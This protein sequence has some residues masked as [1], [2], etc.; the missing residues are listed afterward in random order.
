MSRHILD[1]AKGASESQN[2]QFLTRDRLASPHPA[3]RMLQQRPRKVGQ[4]SQR[5]S[6]YARIERE[7]RN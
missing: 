2:L 4:V 1:R 3:S 5:M 7:N 6:M